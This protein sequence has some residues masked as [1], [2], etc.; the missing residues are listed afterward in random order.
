[1]TRLLAQP[2]ALNTW[3][4]NE[5]Q[6]LTDRVERAQSLGQKLAEHLEL[7]AANTAQPAGPHDLLKHFISAEIRMRQLLLSHPAPLI[8]TDNH[9]KILLTNVAAKQLLASL[10]YDFSKVKP[11]YPL[12]DEVFPALEDGQELEVEVAN[13]YTEM[14]EA[15]FLVRET[16][17][18]WQQDP[19]RILLF[20]DISVEVSAR[21][22]LEE[23]V[24]S[25]EEVNR[26]K[27]EFVSMATH[28]F[29]TPLASIYSSLEL[30][31]RYCEKLS[32]E[33]QSNWIAKLK[34]HLTRSEEAIKH[35]DGLVQEM[36]LLEKTQA[37]RMPC[38]PYPLVVAQ[39]VEE[40]IESLS[41]LAEQL[42]I[43]LAFTCP[44]ELET[45]AINLD[46]KLVRHIITNLL[47][48]ALRF[49]SAGEAVRV[50][51]SLQDQMLCIEVSDEG[52][53]IPAED[54]QALGEPFY[55]ASNVDHVQGT[56]L[57]L[58]IVKRFVDLHQGEL[59]ITS[60]LGVGSQFLVRLPTDLRIKEK[61]DEPNHIAG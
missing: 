25:L 46:A 20:H 60:Q 3:L 32:E 57:G 5:R 13:P 44:P 16:R 48:N 38:L 34:K 47:S 43:P 53:G 17:I 45:Q 22:K 35:L 15:V 14:K 7:K 42:R 30:M 58:S 21:Q 4:A 50:S 9:G 33:S 54:L 24:A 52:R 23:A 27:S 26:F 31:E 40:V 28:E 2:I 29:R 39:L 59:Q 51:L 36:L 11:E 18:Q 56:G 6:A 55:R 41:A 12:I 8:I 49:S 1:M 19:A 37:G 10:G 61:E